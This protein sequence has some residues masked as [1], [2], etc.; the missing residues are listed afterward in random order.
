M[1]PAHPLDLLRGDEIIRGIALLR[2]AGHLGDGTRVVH[3]TLDEPEKSDLAAHRSGDPVDRAVRALV[4]GRQDLDL[5][6][7]VVS[8]TAGEVR[9]VRVHQGMRPALLFGESLDAIVKLREPPDWVEALERRG[10]DDPK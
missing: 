4:A 5:L 10:I 3:G 9:E 1:T 6:E 2:A 7:A 8:V